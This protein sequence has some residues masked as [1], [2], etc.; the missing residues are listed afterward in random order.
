MLIFC[1]DYTSQLLL[2]ISSLRQIF[3]WKHFCLPIVLYG[4][5][6]FTQ[7]LPRPL[8][9]PLI[10]LPFLPRCRFLF[11]S[12]VK[13]ILIRYVL[14]QRY[15]LSDTGV[16][17]NTRFRTLFYGNLL[18]RATHRKIPVQIR[19]IMILH[20]VTSIMLA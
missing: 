15:Q 10:I 20:K 13:K 8:Y 14:A 16:H 18:L 2:V 11:T 17:V 19:I 6:S 3:Y 5:C 1:G 7:L 4:S 12:K 9:I